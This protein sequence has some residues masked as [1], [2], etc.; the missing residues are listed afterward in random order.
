MQILKIFK[1]IAD[2]NT[3]RRSIRKLKKFINKI[4]SEEKQF[5]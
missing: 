2:K 5:I 4:D 3:N 1:R